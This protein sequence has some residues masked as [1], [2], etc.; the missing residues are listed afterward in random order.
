MAGA[1]ADPRRA[2]QGARAEALDRGPLVG[3]HRLDV[4]VLT[5]Q[6]VVV[7]RVRDRGFEQLAPVS[8]DRSRRVSEDSSRILD[9]LAANVVA[10]EPRLA[11]RGPHVL[12]LS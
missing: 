3:V 1:L 8:R 7:L 5:D 9:S 10:D 12:R 2:T 6:L 4:Q 11:R